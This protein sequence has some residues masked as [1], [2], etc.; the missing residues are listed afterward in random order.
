[1]SYT[2]TIGKFFNLNFLGLQIENYSGD[3]NNQSAN[4]ETDKNII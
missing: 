3:I 1:M 2:S 4:S